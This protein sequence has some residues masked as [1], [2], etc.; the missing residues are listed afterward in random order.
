[1]SVGHEQNMFQNAEDFELARFMSNKVAS[2]FSKIR[3]TPKQTVNKMK[4]K[5]IEGKT[6]EVGKNLQ[7]CLES[8]EHKLNE[9]LAEAIVD[10]NGAKVQ[11]RRSCSRCGHMSNPCEVCDVFADQFTTHEVKFES[12]KY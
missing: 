5:S 2:Y 6:V 4:R 3:K 11:L 10:N 12:L 7:T 9:M 8:L 1:M